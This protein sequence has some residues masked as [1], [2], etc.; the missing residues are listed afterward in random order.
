MRN[1]KQ[2]AGHPLEIHFLL[3]LLGNCA[4]STVRLKLHLFVSHCF[5]APSGSRAKGGKKK[6]KKHTR[7]RLLRLKG[8]QEGSER[9][10]TSGGGEKSDRERN[11][12]LT[13][14][15]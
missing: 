12:A 4:L 13:T 10:S 2:K 3:Y 11:R 6:K 15:R 5:F 8:I 1:H 7:N 14:T 9:G